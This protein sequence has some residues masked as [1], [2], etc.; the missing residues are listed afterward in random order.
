MYE[1][2]I[3]ES[4]RLAIT[5]FYGQR[6]SKFFRNTRKRI[7]NK[8]SLFHIVLQAVHDLRAMGPSMGIH[9]F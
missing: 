7:T 2:C 4:V 9:T 8:L 6:H 1:K 3:N 5:D